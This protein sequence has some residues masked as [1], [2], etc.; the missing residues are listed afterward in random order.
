MAK[1][2]RV[3]LLGCTRDKNFTIDY[4]RKV[5]APGISLIGAHTIA[6]PQVESHPGYFT[7]RD[8]LRTT[9]NLVSLN[10][11]KINDL[12]SEM[13]NPE[14]C[15]KIYDRLIEGVDYP[16]CVQFDWNRLSE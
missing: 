6:R 8:D 7:H 2:G 12:V 16:V 3:A 13:H 4:Y 9:L 14:D 15:S 5:H 1:F 11:L 10:R